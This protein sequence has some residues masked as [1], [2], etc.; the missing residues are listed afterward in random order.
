MRSSLDSTPAVDVAVPIAFGVA[1]TEPGPLR[2]E[3]PVDETLLRRLPEI[4]EIFATFR[5]RGRWQPAVPLIN[6]PQVI[7]EPAPAERRR[8]DRGVAAFFS[9]GVDAFATLHRNPQVTHLIYVAGLDVPVDARYQPHHQRLR[10]GVAEVAE[11]LGLETIWIETN[12]RELFYGRGLS[13]A[14]WFGFATGGLSRLV[15]SEARTVLLASSQ[16]HRVQLPNS[17]HP[18]IDHLWGSDQLQVVHEGGELARTEKV[19]LIAANPIARERLRVCWQSHDKTSIAGAARSA[20]GRWWRWRRSGRWATSRPFRMTS[21]STGSPRCDRRSVTR[22]RSGGRT[23]RSR[24]STGPEPTSARRSS[25]RSTARCRSGPRGL[26]RARRPRK[27]RDRGRGRRPS[28]R[29]AI[30]IPVFRQPQ[31]V[32][33]AIR[34]ALESRTE[35]EVAVVVVNDGCPYPSTEANS[36]RAREIDPGR[37]AYLA[38]ENAGLAA[39]R[40]AGVAYALE[41]WPAAEAIFFLDADNELG[42]DAI[43]ALWR[44]LEDD[45]AASWAYAYREMFGAEGGGWRCRAASTPTAS[46]SRTSATPGAS[47]G[48]RSSP[49]TR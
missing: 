1:M 45:P 49:S 43:A 14:A 44:V 36:L 26:Q 39:A 20:C 32:A 8:A 37:T 42:P 6:R 19:E 28:T 22:S 33:N 3:A 38:Q 29:A 31:F 18:M 15:A 17:S 23:W 2:V 24:A 47:Y 9:L 12:V 41:T 16:A 21:T 48:A 10:A 5:H 11:Q 34:S 13:G 7:A 40:N 30:V 25:R 27:P 4:A 46:C 35:F